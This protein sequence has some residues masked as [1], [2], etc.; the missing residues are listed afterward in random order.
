MA[1]EP[2]KPWDSGLSYTYGQ[3][4]TYN[5][6]PYVYWNADTPS[7]AG[8][9]PNEQMATFTAYGLD[10]TGAAASDTRSDRAWVIAD[11]VG[12]GPGGVDFACYG[13]VQD[14]QK[15]VRN[16]PGYVTGDFQ[17]QPA[18]Y[19]PIFAKG[20]AGKKT[21]MSWNYYAPP[22][23]GPGAPATSG[24]STDY[25]VANPPDSP[26]DTSNPNHNFS[27]LSTAVLGYV[28]ESADYVSTN[29][30]V[31]SF[32]GG[33]VSSAT[34]YF[35]YDAGTAGIT[36]P[37]K[38]TWTFTNTVTS[39]VRTVVW[40]DTITTP[41]LTD[42]YVFPNANQKSY[43]TPLPGADETVVRTFET[44]ETTPRYDR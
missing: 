35:I 17:Y 21:V 20:Y 6:L 16:L 27:R 23:V 24:D 25:G 9:K 28:G 2:G 40:E 14:I 7:T 36:V 41:E 13:K 10:S 31:H 1:Y 43:V 15:G 3:T 37:F 38:V 32:G 5:G 30:Y 8:V 34:Y 42:T 4:C 11:R 29:T 26:G 12:Y 19:L 39:A 22:W 44:S 18:H 33:Y